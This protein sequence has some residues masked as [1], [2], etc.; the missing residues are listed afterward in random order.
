MRYEYDVRI[1]M[2]LGMLCL[3]P[4]FQ[5]VCFVTALKLFQKIKDELLYL[6]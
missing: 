3:L 4:I 1:Y 2:A 6:Y 5:I